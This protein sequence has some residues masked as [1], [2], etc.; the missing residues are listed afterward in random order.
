MKSGDKLVCLKDIINLVGL[1]QF[2]KDKTY[3]IIYI[4]N[5]KPKIYVCLQDE[6]NNGE[7]EEFELSWVIK[8]FKTFK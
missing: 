4:N 3:E 7:W 1:V 2:K 6:L 5:E 8:N